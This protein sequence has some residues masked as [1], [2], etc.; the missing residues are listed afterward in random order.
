MGTSRALR[1][2]LLRTGRSLSRPR[3]VGSQDTTHCFQRI[4]V[5]GYA[6][7]GAPLRDDRPPT[8][9]GECRLVYHSSEIYVTELPVLFSGRAHSGRRGSGWYFNVR[10]GRM[11]LRNCHALPS[12]AVEMKVKAHKVELGLTR[13]PRCR[14]E[15]GFCG[16]A[17]RASACWVI[18]HLSATWSC[19]YSWLRGRAT[20]GTC[21]C[22]AVRREPS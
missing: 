16:A 8:Q 21:S 7:N 20:G 22:G 18:Q 2:R 5:L 4:P 17:R 3:V 12:K 14:S 10:R 11:R 15:V 6:S 1:S 13:C 9:S 19:R